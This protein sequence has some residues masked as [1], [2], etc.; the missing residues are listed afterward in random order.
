MGWSLCVHRLL[1]AALP[2]S[3]LSAGPH[4][5]HYPCSDSSRLAD[6]P[7]QPRVAPL[8][9]LLSHLCRKEL[10]GGKSD[11]LSSRA[12]ISFFFWFRPLVVVG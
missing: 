6:P 3:A 7:G 1:A 8:A 5:F 10:G 4:T 2:P 9:D 12:V 11:P